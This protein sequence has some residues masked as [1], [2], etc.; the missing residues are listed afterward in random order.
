MWV[1]TLTFSDAEVC[2]ENIDLIGALVLLFTANGS[3]SVISVNK[4]GQHHKKK[5][6]CQIMHSEHPQS[7]KAG[8]EVL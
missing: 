8:C 2:G 5:P 7:C 6:S 3:S 4:L 1:C